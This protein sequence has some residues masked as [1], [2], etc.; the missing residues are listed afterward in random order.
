MTIKLAT[1]VEI[2]K[3]RRGQ[4]RAF[5]AGTRIR[6]QDIYAM[7][8][9]QGLSPDQIVENLQH[10]SLSEVHGALAFYWDNP[11]AIQRELDEDG[12]FVARMKTL[13][14]PGPLAS[15]LKGNDGDGNSISPR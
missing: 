10:L 8:E 12:D 4:P 5:V 15:K 1:H 9:V 11:E 2:R 6:V 13:L 7:S 14:G 3:N